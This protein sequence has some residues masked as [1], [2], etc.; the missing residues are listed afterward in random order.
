MRKL[1]STNEIY[2]INNFIPEDIDIIDDKNMR[3]IVTNIL[4]NIG[5]P[6][7]LSGY[8][9]LREAILMSIK[10]KENLESVTKILYPNL[11]KTFNSTPI[12]VERAIRHAI[13]VGW[14]R[15]NTQF[16]KELFGYTINCR[17]NKPTNSE[18]IALLSDALSLKYY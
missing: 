16:L 14:N 12:R 2:G 8:S 13:E 5:I 18:F 9:Y 6:P 10:N 3:L 11:A 15:G 4:H 1:I 7:N 17:K